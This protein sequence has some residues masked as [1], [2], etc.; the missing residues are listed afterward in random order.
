M[1]VQEKAQIKAKRVGLSPG[2]AITVVL[3]ETRIERGIE[4]A[5][6]ALREP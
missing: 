6:D 4:T 3:K 2:S 5:F 1:Q